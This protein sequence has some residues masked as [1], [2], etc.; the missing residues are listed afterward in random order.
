MQ[1]A[2]GDPQFA[3]LYQSCFQAGAGAAVDIETLRAV[4][5]E[6]LRATG[7][8]SGTMSAQQQQLTAMCQVRLGAAC[9]ADAAAP[10][11]LNINAVCCMA[12]PQNEHTLAAAA[13]HVAATDNEGE[14]KWKVSMDGP[15]L[16]PATTTG[17]AAKTFE[18][19][20]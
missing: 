16:P 1:R 6:L 10:C 20:L 9:V 8:S 12:L 3:K 18:H 7:G 14:A 17:S 13:K 19:E 2:Q 15:T 5:K 4:C 11:A